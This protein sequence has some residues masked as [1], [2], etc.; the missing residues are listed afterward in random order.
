MVTIREIMS[1]DLK[2]VTPETS[3]RQ[4]A[5]FLI[6][7]HVSG[8]PVLASGRVVGVVSATDLLEFDTEGR[9]VPTLR[10]AADVAPFQT[11]DGG[12]EGDAPAA[13]FADMWADSG[14][15]VQTRLASESPEWNA[16]DDHV[17]DEV[18]TR[19]LLTLAPDA[20][21]R[22]AARRMII[23]GVHR[24][25]VMKDEKLVGLVTTSDLVNAIASYGLD[26]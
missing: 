10:P 13:Y 17:V 24:L 22:E 21:V 6:E 18:M 12:G 8:V 23:G 20:D 15:E 7:E 25:L 19:S 4:L 3:L 1:T 26:G 11:E 14:A 9:A 5:E 2:A 16:L